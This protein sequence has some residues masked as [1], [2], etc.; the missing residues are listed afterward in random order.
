MTVQPLHTPRFIRKTQLGAQ[1]YHK[2]FHQIDNDIVAAITSE[3]ADRVTPLMSKIYLRLK[4]APAE[5]WERDGVLRFEAETSQGK[6]IKAWSVLCKLVGVSSETANKAVRWMHEQGII[7]YFAGKNGVG[8]RIFMNR[9]VASIGVR[10]ASGGKKILRMAPASPAH[11]RGSEGEAAFNDT[12]GVKDIL[13]PDIN[14]HAP[15]SGA[16][17]DE[18]AENSGDSAEGPSVEG[19]CSPRAV[20]SSNDLSLADVVGRLKSELEPSLRTVAVQVARVEQE[21]TRAWLETR[22]LPKAARVAQREAYNVLR[23]KGMIREKE[24]RT[25]SGCEE[26]PGSYVPPTAQPL[27][28]ER[29]T[30]CAEICLAML[31]VQGKAVDVTLAEIS[32]ENGGFVLP[33]DLVK[34]RA[35]ANEMIDR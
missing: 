19:E 28:E 26:E 25:R 4:N 35:A 27:T 15:E 13:D 21:R 16:D 14:P 23:N 32:A 29:I 34:V 8:I 31:E 12:Y 24:D 18:V 33:E 2:N 17:K 11:G 9:A 5:Y 6:Q 10:S 22:G 20:T 1:E 3:E 30:E 7:G